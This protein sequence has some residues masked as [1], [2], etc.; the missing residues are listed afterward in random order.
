MSLLQIICRSQRKRCLA[1][2]LVELLVVLAV[3]GLLVA[4][5]LPAVQQAREAARRTQ[6]RS[7]LHQFGVA[8]HNYQ[9]TYQMFPAGAM[10]NLSLHVSL[11]PYVDQQALYDKFRAENPDDQF[12]DAYWI[13][14]MATHRIPLFHCPSDPWGDVAVEG[15]HVDG[16][17]LSVYGTNYVGNY[18]TGVQT[19]GYNGLFRYHNPVKPAEVTDGLSNTAMMSEW[20]VGTDRSELARSVWRTPYYL[21]A[22]DQLEQ[23]AHLCRN[24]ALSNPSGG[25]RKG[26]AWTSGFMYETGYNHVLFP[27][28]ASCTNFGRS[29]EGGYSASSL[30][31]GMV[32]LLAADG[33]VRSISANLDLKVWRALGSRDGS[34]SFEFP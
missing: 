3:I 5:L 27:N 32:H 6:C 11:L 17:L 18:G 14:F 21:L 12:Y 33:H 23:F 10:R 8:L 26:G 16:T 9:S 15:Q 28:D 1:F 31:Y 22:P 30:H 24:T 29:R 34:E 25:Y 4:L 7:H 20:L 2:T 19:Y 13:N